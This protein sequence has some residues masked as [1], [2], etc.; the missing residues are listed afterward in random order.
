MYSVTLLE[1]HQ[2]RAE[3]SY[4]RDVRDRVDLAIQQSIDLRIAIL[5]AKLDEDRQST[6][7]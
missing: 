7:A 3:L 6:P 1:R 5:E 2:M 4:L